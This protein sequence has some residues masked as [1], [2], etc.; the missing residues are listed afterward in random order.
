VQLKNSQ[1]KMLRVRD[2]MNR[3]SWLPDRRMNETYRDRTT[4]FRHDSTRCGLSTGRHKI[5]THT[6]TYLLHGAEYYLK[7]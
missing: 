6:H 4:L 5:Y 7:N 1:Q 3:P 2:K